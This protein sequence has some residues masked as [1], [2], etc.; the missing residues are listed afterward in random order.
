MIFELMISVCVILK[1]KFNCFR[2]FFY[3]AL[4]LYF[5]DLSRFLIFCDVYAFYLVLNI[6]LYDFIVFSKFLITSLTFLK[7]FIDFHKSS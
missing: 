3:R 6:D 5:R 1:T 7:C 4:L 2:S